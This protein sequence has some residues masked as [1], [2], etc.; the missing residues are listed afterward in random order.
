MPRTRGKREPHEHFKDKP[1]DKPK[2]K[3][4]DKVKVKSAHREGPS[5]TSAADLADVVMQPPETNDAK[6][7]GRD[8]TPEV[9]IADVVMTDAPVAAADRPS[10]ASEAQLVTPKK[11]PRTAMPP[12]E[13]GT[14]SQASP[15]KRGKNKHKHKAQPFGSARQ[16]ATASTASDTRRSRRD[17]GAAS[18][19]LASP[20]R[21]KAHVRPIAP[22]PT[23]ARTFHEMV[24]R[25]SSGSA[26]D[27]KKAK[28]LITIGLQQIDTFKDTAEPGQPNWA[29]L[30]QKW[31]YGYVERVVDDI[32]YRGLT[33]KD[34]SS[35]SNCTAAETIAR[36]G[37]EKDDVEQVLR[38]FNVAFHALLVRQIR[39][40]GRKTIPRDFKF[41]RPGWV[42]DVKAI[43]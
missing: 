2:S 34:G 12:Q 9:A 19:T 20:A 18:A 38:V 7:P 33:L 29:F 24:A 22:T 35:S 39:L 28:Q 26:Q 15:K 11:R 3:S 16:G 31:P 5:G 6:A 42:A 10:A 40:T 13:Q 30:R 25:L 43:F 23:T 4:S 32:F 41:L 8:S 17:G 14:G 1:P 21:S 37:F 36:L 27:V